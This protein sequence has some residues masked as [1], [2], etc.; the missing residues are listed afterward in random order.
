MSNNNPKVW[1]HGTSK[2]AWQRIR[3]EGA[4]WGVHK[5][6]SRFTYLALEKEEADCYG[7]ITL[8]VEYDAVE[9]IRDNNFYPD[10][11]E[12]KVINPIKISKI[13]RIR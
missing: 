11:L 2:R 7:D 10:C 12:V 13:K 4:L 8:K 1:Y 6:G 3:K 9:D 5:N